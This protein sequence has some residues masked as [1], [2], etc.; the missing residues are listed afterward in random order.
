MGVGGLGVVLIQET[1]K[2]VHTNSTYDVIRKIVPIWNYSVIEKV[3]PLITVF[4]QFSNMTASS[5]Q[6]ILVYN[7]LSGPVDRFKFI[8]YFVLLY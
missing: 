6:S 7:W 8:M 5:S 3:E 4:D 2:R 1:L